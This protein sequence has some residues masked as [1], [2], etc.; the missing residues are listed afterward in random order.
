MICWAAAVIPEFH[1]LLAGAPA[2]LMLTAQ[3]VTNTGRP[4][5]L[6][7][8]LQARSAA[9]GQELRIAGLFCIL[10]TSAIGV[11]LPLLSRGRFPAALFIARCFGAGVVLATGFAHVSAVA[12]ER[13]SLHLDNHVH[14]ACAQLQCRAMLAGRLS[15]AGAYGWRF[16]RCCST[17][18]QTC[19]IHAWGG[20]DSTR[21]AW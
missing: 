17:Q 19:R 1:C 18:W 21:S 16:C 5:T 9:E 13:F 12:F 3:V 15:Q 7:P 4:R 20:I 6:L 10:A 14:L 11:S 2:W 8:N